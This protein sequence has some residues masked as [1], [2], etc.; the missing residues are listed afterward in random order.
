[1]RW[2]VSCVS[3]IAL[4]DGLDAAAGLLP[5]DEL[6]ETVPWANAGRASSV[7]AA[8]TGNA[9]L[10]IDRLRLGL[11]MPCQRR[12]RAVRSRLRLLPEAA[13][14]SFVERFYNRPDTKPA[15]GQAPH[16]AKK[17]SRGGDHFAATRGAPKGGTAAG[18]LR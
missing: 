16:R 17:R 11:W 6:F 7:A 13:S 14:R 3:F 5:G 15:V 10:R 2:R 9:S 18:G 4:G 12:R 8:K 1:M